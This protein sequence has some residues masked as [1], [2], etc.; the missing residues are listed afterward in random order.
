MYLPSTNII[1]REGRMISK[2]NSICLAFPFISTNATFD[3]IAI[4]YKPNYHSTIKK[5]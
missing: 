5:G 3:R 4:G 2:K 1:N